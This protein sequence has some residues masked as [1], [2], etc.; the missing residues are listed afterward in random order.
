MKKID[1]V[2]T[3]IFSGKY[4]FFRLT[5]TFLVSIS[6]IRIIIQVF[7]LIEL[8]GDEAQY[9]EWSRRMAWCYYSKPPGVAALIWIGTHIFGNNELGV[10]FMSI[11]CSFIS[12]IAVYFLGKNM[13]DSKTGCISAILFLVIPAFSIYGIGITPDSPLLMFWC[14]SLLWFY[15]AVERE[16][17]SCWLYLTISIGLA[18]L[19]KYAIIFFIVPAILYML[20]SS[21]GRKSLKTVW[22]YISIPSSM[23]FFIP[24]I[25]WNSH[26]NW[27]TF[28]HDLGHTNA[29]EGFVFSFQYLL[30]FIGGQLMIVTPVTAAAI[31]ILLTKKRKEYHFCFWFCI[32][33]LICFLLKSFQGKI[34]AN[35][36]STA[37]VS[38]VIP[39]AHFFS[40]GYWQLPENNKWRTISRSTISIPAIAI[41]I[42]H[43]SFV[44]HLIPGTNKIPAIKRITGWN[45]L[46]SEVDSTLKDMPKPCFIATDY[47]MI[48]AELAFY[49]KDNPT[50]YYMNVGKSRMNQYDLWPGVQDIIGQNAI[51]IPRKGIKESIYDAFDKV[52]FTEFSTTNLYG[53]KMQTYKI[54]KCYGFKGI[55]MQLSHTY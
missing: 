24:V 4:D 52:E 7:G 55:D 39:L 27:V 35:W 9:W 41:I 54:C 42:V 1:H 32:P 43:C 37:W 21:Q 2:V 47:Y 34:Q 26:N 8:S 6:L 53:D 46:A 44:I 45:Q 31:I 40:C 19:C 29:A 10:R 30:N 17:K 15:L 13:F 3:E 49:C 28:R 20:M 51:F 11:L 14:L 23:L 38:G 22:P 18:M 48:T 5:L 12:S 25:Y 33:I 16:K 50:T 36:V